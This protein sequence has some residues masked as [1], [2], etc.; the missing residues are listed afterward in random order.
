M[1]MGN[2]NELSEC[3]LKIIIVTIRFNITQ[4]NTIFLKH[5]AW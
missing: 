3:E 4:I 5:V 1:C 2:S